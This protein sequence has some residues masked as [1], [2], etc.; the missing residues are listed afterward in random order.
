MLYCIEKEKNRH[1]HCGQRGGEVSNSFHY[2]Y[3]THN[4]LQTHNFVNTAQLVIE[5]FSLYLKLYVESPKVWFTR[6]AS[7]HVSICLAMQA[8]YILIFACLLH[9]ACDG[10]WPAHACFLKIAFVCDIYMCVCMRTACVHL[11]F[12]SCQILCHLLLFRSKA[13]LLG[14]FVNGLIIISYVYGRWVETTFIPPYSL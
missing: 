6:L 5:Q 7:C 10:L 8:S 2:L 11:L 13:V 14:Y 9:Q 4:E 1:N 12:S 3:T